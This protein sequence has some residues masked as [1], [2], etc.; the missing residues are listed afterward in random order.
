MTLSAAICPG[1]GG[2]VWECV[3]VLS[4]LTEMTGT[5]V[6]WTTTTTKQ[7]DTLML[8]VLSGGS[9]PAVICLDCINNSCYQLL[10]RE[11]S[12][13]H[14][15]S[16]TLTCGFVN[17]RSGVLSAAT[18]LKLWCNVG[19]SRGHLGVFQWALKWF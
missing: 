4:G 17:L 9:S 14:L 19:S 1:I 16:C 15:A 5:D 12:R 3:C 7:T 11:Q 10:K 13:A 18:F 8:V 6:V 2:P